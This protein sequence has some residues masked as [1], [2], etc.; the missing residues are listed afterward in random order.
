MTLDEAETHVS[1][2]S[3]EDNMYSTAALQI[4][5]AYPNKCNSQDVL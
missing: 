1:L 2:P 5:D 3:V 4:D